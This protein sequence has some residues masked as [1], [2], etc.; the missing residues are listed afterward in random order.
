MQ[1]VAS[2]LPRRLPLPA[3]FCKLQT[4]LAD[5]GYEPLG[6]HP[7]KP[8]ERVTTDATGIPVLSFWYRAQGEAGELRR[9]KTWRAPPTA[10]RPRRRPLAPV[11]EASLPR[12]PAGGW[13]SNAPSGG[14][15]CFA[16]ATG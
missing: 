8:K 13:G 9:E 1:S 2:V 4:A 7:D 12:T 3:S 5:A 16:A 10:P 14:V 15:G 6:E 11:P